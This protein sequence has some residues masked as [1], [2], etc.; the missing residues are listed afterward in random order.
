MG[1]G[2]VA[3]VA[4]IG[5]GAV[6]CAVARRFALDGAS[7]LLLEKGADLLSGASKANS[8]ILHTG[9]DAPPGSVE[10]ACMQAGYREYLAIR[11]GFNLPVL[12]TGAMVVAWSRAEEAAL[13]AIAAQAVGNG[14]EDVR[15][16][17][18]AE[19]AEREPHL[20]PARAALLV[21]GE[22]VIDPWS[23][24]LAYLRQATALGARLS[25]STEVTGGTF[26]GEVWTLDT[27]RGAFR[28]RSVINC[29]GL[30]GD[31]IEALLLGAAHFEIRP[32]K[33]QFVVFDKAASALL[34]S[35]VLP[36]PTERTKGVVLCRT[37]FGNVLVGPTAEEQQDREHAA[38]DGATL[39]ALIRRAV[40]MVPA[41]ARMDV[42]ATYA[43]LRPASEEK[44]Y[45]IV[46]RPEL[47]WITVGGI[48][49]TGLTAS[50]GIA[51]HVARLYRDTKEAKHHLPSRLAPSVSMPN[52]A[53]HLPRDW[54][55]PGHGGIVCHCELVTLREIEAALGGEVPARDFGGLRRRTRCA[56]GRCQGF[57]CL[58]RLAE[59]TRGRL[60]VPLA[61]G[62]GS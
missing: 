30:F 9:F 34:R 22:H 36:V 44:H 59:L 15:L 52:L 16:L 41:L 12:E 31:R 26:N 45:R 6:G 56:M 3:D 18:A 46:A 35:I 37:A 25:F 55:S 4:V 10:L 50:L 58:G 47:R 38:T 54:Q 24:F 62:G 53:E 27:T 20:A 23:P 32:R 13:P 2:V 42:T 43:G 21:P 14:V 7:V 61:E 49:S 17:T 5:A 39:Q 51:Q 19:I 57:G 60:Q 48:R 33:G 11:E 8:A 40:E 1:A 29:A 28:A